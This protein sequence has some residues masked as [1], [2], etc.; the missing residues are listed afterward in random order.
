MP[1]ELVD[2]LL[3][4]EEDKKEEDEDKGMDFESLMDMLYD[5]EYDHDQ[6]TKMVR[7]L[8]IEIILVVIFHLCKM[9]YFVTIQTQ[10]VA[11][12]DI[13]KNKKNTCVNGRER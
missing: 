4:P 5:D 11:L 6:K 8:W 13:L 2:V 7:D 10:N 12:Y 1:E 3:E 9:L